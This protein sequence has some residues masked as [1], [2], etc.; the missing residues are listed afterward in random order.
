MAA[1]GSSRAWGA[2]VARG[3]WVSPSTLSTTISLTVCSQDF[4]SDG[5]FTPPARDVSSI[6]SEYLESVFFLI[7]LGNFFFLLE[8][9]KVGDR[10]L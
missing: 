7:F 9:L 10:M 4:D 3:E 5:P 8:L 6:A 2:R 1:G